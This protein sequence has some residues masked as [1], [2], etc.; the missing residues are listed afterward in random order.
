MIKTYICT[1]IKDEFEYLKEWCEYHLN[2]GFDK[3]FLFED[4]ESKSHKKLNLPSKCEIKSL[5]E[6]LEDKDCSYR[7]INLFNQFCKENK[8]C[9]CL[10]SDIDEFLVFEEGWDLQRFIYEFRCCPSVTLFWDLVT[11]SGHIKRPQGKILDNYT[12]HI[13]LSK[14]KI[15]GFYFKCFANLNYR[16]EFINVHYPL[17]SV[18]T[19]KRYME[20][21]YLKETR[22][23]EVAKLNHYLSKSFQDWCEKL[24]GTSLPPKFRTIEDF[25]NMNPSFK[26]CQDIMTK[27]YNDN[28]TDYDN[29]IKEINNKRIIE[30]SK[31]V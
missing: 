6:Y 17:Y 10:F 21:P 26:D 13:E 4:F 11:S 16:V 3:I 12:E 28:R 23:Y 9:W 1:I 7:Q 19:S 8:N 27:F 14:S 22:T 18:L 25:F 15:K 2:L 30:K 31:S 20:I 24:R 29:L 5:Y